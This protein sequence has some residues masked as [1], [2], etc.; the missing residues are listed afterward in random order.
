MQILRKNSRLSTAHLVS[1]GKCICPH[2]VTKKKADPTFLLHQEL[3]ID[4]QCDAM[5]LC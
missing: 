3:N 4:S 5:L 2:L 1:K